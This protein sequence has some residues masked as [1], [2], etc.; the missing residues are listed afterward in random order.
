MPKKDEVQDDVARTQSLEIKTTIKKDTTLN[1]LVWQENGT[2]K[3]YLM[4]VTAV[5]NA[6]KKHGHLDNY[7]K[8]AWAYEKAKKAIESTRAGLALLDK[9]GENV[10][11]SSKK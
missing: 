7:E 10:K 6:I 4:H 5:I 2:C 9:A 1:F 3:A 11:K 8:A